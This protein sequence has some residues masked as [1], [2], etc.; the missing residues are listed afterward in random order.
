VI[1]LG[2][3]QRVLVRQTEVGECGLA[4]IAMISRHHRDTGDMGELR[5]R[6]PLSTRG[7]NLKE[8]VFIGDQLGFH[9]R[10]LQSDISSLSGM[11]FPA[12]LHW[13]INHFVVLYRISTRFG[14]LRFVILDPA[15]GVCSLDESEFSKH[16]TGIVL[17]LTPTASFKPKKQQQPIRLTDL[18]SKI[19]GF[20]STTG[21]VLGLS[22]ALQTIVLVMPFYMQITIDSVLPDMDMDLM[23]VLALG[24]G[25]LALIN[26]AT[27]WFRLNLVLALGTDLIFQTTVNLFRH[28]I[29]LPIAWF[30]KRHLGDVISRF[31][32]LQPVSDLLSRGLV[33]VIVDGGLAFATLV[34]MFIYSPKLSLLSVFAVILYCMLRFAYLNVL[35][36]ANI[37]LLSAQAIENTTFI[38]NIRGIHA[39]K[40]FCQEENRQ[41]HWQN[42]KAVHV[43][44]VLNIGRISGGFDVAGALIVALEGIVFLFVGIGMIRTGS[45]SLGMLFALQAYKLSFM[46]A[47]LRLIDQMMNYKITGVHLARVADLVNENPEPGW[48]SESIGD[49]FTRI[50]LRNVSFSYG[51]GSGFVLKNV[52]LSMDRTE[53]VAIVGP[54]GSGKTTLLKILSG[55]LMP[56]Q[57]EILVDGTPLKD[58]GIRNYR[59]QLGIVSQE[60]VLFSGT[61]AENIAFFDPNHQIEDIFTAAKMTEVH[62]D[63]IQF[64]MKYETHVSDMGSNLSGG[65]RQRIVLARALYKTPRLLLLDEATAHLDV[66]TEHKVLTNITNKDAGCILVAHRPDAYR[67]ANRILAIHQGNVSEMRKNTIGSAPA[68]P[69]L[70][71]GS[72]P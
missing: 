52:N 56:T 59:S 57:G 9:S 39:I 38:E 25:I 70:N 41:R 62:E 18:W 53:F 13:D 67:Q 71:S 20:W 21:K 14:R 60:D 43:N 28:V 2:R 50:E 45:L 24:F 64:P 34:L 35:K 27:S 11:S 17:E 10:A 61:L 8:L 3:L 6:F 46:N 16:F 72:A 63:I 69:L 15:N 47:L 44:A 58:Y 33:S 4:C 31:G 48:M 55:L 51:M 26:A 29:H 68:H 12:I 54:S 5:R 23:Y 30:E 19:T 22:I 32:S 66:S 1:G 65:Q 37:N 7:V 40:S 36:N 42:K 49:G